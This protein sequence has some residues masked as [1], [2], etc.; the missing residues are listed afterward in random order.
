MQRMVENGTYKPLTIE[1]RAQARADRRRS[2]REREHRR[3]LRSKKRCEDACARY[4]AG[5]RPVTRSESE[6]GRN[7]DGAWPE[8]KRRRYSGRQRRSKYYI[9]RGVEGAGRTKSFCSELPR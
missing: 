4:C 7:E 2:E 5:R 6:A 8:F 1:T 9:K 3:W